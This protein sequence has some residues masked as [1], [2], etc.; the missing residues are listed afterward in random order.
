MWCRDNS[1]GPDPDHPAGLGRNRKPHSTTSPRYKQAT[2]SKTTKG[3]G[4]EWFL[5][6]HNG[7]SYRHLSAT[8]LPPR[9]HRSPSCLLDCWQ[10]H[11]S[12]TFPSTC[13]NSGPISRLR[14]GIIPFLLRLCKKWIVLPPFRQ[15]SGPIWCVFHLVVVSEWLLHL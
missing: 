6:H 3:G 1:K 4:Y 7:N 2:E 9:L 10:H 13:Q 14:L 5:G 15:T 11:L 12:T 8:T